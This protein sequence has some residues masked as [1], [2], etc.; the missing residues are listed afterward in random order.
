MNARKSRQH[1]PRYGHIPGP[2][3]LDELLDVKVGDLNQTCGY[4]LPVAAAQARA[5]DTLSQRPP[6]RITQTNLTTIPPTHQLTRTTARRP[7]PH[8]PQ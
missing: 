7:N 1:P 4:W 2:A 5:E 3:G 6:A 8:D